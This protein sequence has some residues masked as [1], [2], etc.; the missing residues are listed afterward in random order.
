MIYILLLLLCLI[1]IGFTIYFIKDYNHRK[2]IQ[3]ANRIEKEIKILGN[4][5]P[6]K[7]VYTTPLTNFY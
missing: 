2:F 3:T 1:F 5:T 4:N 7:N 6:L